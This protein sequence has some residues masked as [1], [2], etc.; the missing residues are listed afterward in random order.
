M[1]KPSECFPGYVEN[2]EPLTLILPRTSYEEKALTFT[3]D[4][5]KFALF[6]S[7]G[8]DQV[9]RFME[10]NGDHDWRGLLVP[11]VEIELDET[12]LFDVDGHYPPLGSLVRHG[13]KLSVQTIALGNRFSPYGGQFPIMSE[14]P[15]ISPTEKAC[16]TK[17][18]IVLGEGQEKRVLHSV[19]ATPQG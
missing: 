3:A 12:S 2:A 1:L 4:S 6:L 5:K 18:Q 19:N 14:L 8:A 9:F 15:S 17:W 10:R 16:F 11:N 13:D 7:G